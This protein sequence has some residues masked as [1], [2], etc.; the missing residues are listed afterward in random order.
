MDEAIGAVVI[1]YDGT[2]GP[3]ARNN[4]RIVRNPSRA[5][6]TSQKPTLR[7]LGANRVIVGPDYFR[8]ADDT[9][10]DTGLHLSASPTRA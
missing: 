6:A 3:E 4:M 2:C 9:A 5:A 10:S 7:L 8:I 1:P